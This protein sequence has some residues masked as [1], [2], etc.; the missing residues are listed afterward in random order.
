VILPQIHWDGFSRFSL[1]TGGDG[2]SRFGL[3]T[4]GFGFSGLDLKTD[5]YGLMICISKLLSQFLG[6]TSKPSGLRFIG[7]TTKLIG[8]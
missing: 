5:C 8:G 7:Y 3:K 6:L 2:F 4:G 1:K